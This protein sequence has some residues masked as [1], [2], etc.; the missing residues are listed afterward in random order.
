M[1]LEID[2]R[3][4]VIAIETAVDLVGMNDTSHGK[5]VG[6]MASQIAYAL[7]HPE[8]AVQEIFELGLLHD[9]GVSSDQ[10]HVNLVNH[11]DWK[12]VHIHCEIGHNLLREFEPLRH[13]AI[14]ILHHHTPWKELKQLG[15]I[16]EQDRFLANLIFLVDRVD[17]MSAAH[18]GKDIL[19]ARE[20]VVE[21]IRSYQGDYFD[22]ELVEVFIA[23]QHTEAFWI[24]LE[25]RYINSFSE[26][27][28][29]CK[30][31][32]HL[33]YRQLKQMA[34]ILAY[35][36]DQKSP[37]TAQHSARVAVLARFLGARIGLS[38]TQ[39]NKIEIAGFLHD[40]GKLRTPDEILQKPGPLSPL[41]RAII[42]NHSFDT[43][44]IL[45]HIEGLE[46]IAIWA[47]YHHEEVGRR[48]YPFHPKENAFTIE[49]RVIAVADVFQALVQDRPYRSGMTLAEVEQILRQ[50]VEEKKLDR[51]V[52]RSALEVREYCYL[53]A[54]GNAPE[55]EGN[56]LPFTIV[57]RIVE[58]KV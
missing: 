49:A 20:G 27:M 25:D 17:V 34:M 45:R 57:P 23:I 9:C 40:L 58:E 5:R 44:E 12:D 13:L 21:A 55:N 14:P 24:A 26:D 30:R 42:I 11:F 35:I 37:Y 7:G 46:D 41:E 52:V 47:A 15:G 6:C 56:E 19:L 39:I 32:C 43:Y 36:V 50:F 2:Y 10:V 53:I 38:E 8:E 4:M 18:Y 54:Q 29:R 16:S 31:R 28:G 22:P 1:G 51:E 3:Q 33:D 48:G